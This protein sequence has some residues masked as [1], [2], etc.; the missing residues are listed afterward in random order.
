MLR[1]SR[2]VSRFHR[3]GALYLYHDAFGYLLEGSSDIAEVVDAFAAP[4]PKAEVCELLG[5][6]IEGVG[7]FID[8]LCQHRVLVENNADAL[9]ELDS[10]FPLRARWSAVQIRP[11]RRLAAVEGRNTDIAPKLRLLNDLEAG[12]WRLMDG[13][14][15]VRTIAQRLFSQR[16]N[17]GQASR[18]EDLK[19][20]T[21]VV[22]VIV[23]NFVHSDRQWARVSQVPVSQYR[24]GRPRPPYLD[25]TMPYASLKPGEAVPP[26]RFSADGIVDLQAYHRDEISDAPK[27]F[28]LGETTM[29]HMFRDPHPALANRTFTAAL[30]DALADNGLLGDGTHEW[31]EVGG[32]T[33]AFA[34]GMCA[35]IRAK[36]P[37]IYEQMRYS[38]V[39]ISPVLQASQQI[40]LKRHRKATRTLTLDAETLL[41]PAN[42]VDFLVCN[43]VIADLRTAH[44]SAADLDPIA[45][46]T[47]TQTTSAEALEAIETYGL[48]VPAGG[49]D[50]F[51]NLGA[52]RFLERVAVVLRPGGGAYVSEF[53]DQWRFP[54]ESTQ[55]DHPEFS[56]H[57]GHMQRV[58]EQLGLRAR[59]VS[60]LDF[61][62]FAP[63]VTT[64]SATRT[65][66]RNV[67]WLLQKHGVTLEKIAYTRSQLDALFGDQF[68]VRALPSLQFKPLSERALGLRCADFLALVIQK[69]AAEVAKP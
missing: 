22:R 31:V 35:A 46:L 66:F 48:A 58:V 12:V 32:G 38:V 19:T 6:R 11:D 54:L 28:D 25:S 52:I 37:A 5:A 55:L 20:F 42:S 2:H 9:R 33:G 26:D 68:D 10:L 16:D 29:S 21:A 62:E 15:N 43:E 60:V 36:L 7:S 56:I 13:D 39:D 49:E 40:A 51:I 63:E 67:A 27:Q 23:A 3:R 57:F 24:S 18:I 45:K 61:L 8:V 64:V 50:F 65:W 53:G 30:L 41:L 34:S 44:V 1:R 69:P 47:V 14:L 17:T 4:R 59:V